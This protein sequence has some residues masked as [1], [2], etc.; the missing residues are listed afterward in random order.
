MSHLS[1]TAGADV[2]TLNRENR[3]AGM[4]FFTTGGISWGKADKSDQRGGKQEQDQQDRG[5]DA[6]LSSSLGGLKTG[7]S[8]EGVS[9]LRAESGLDSLAMALCFSGAPSS[10][11]AG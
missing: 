2:G 9:S 6:I 1:G 4:M 10:A 5:K 7:N 11:G 3:G 8:S